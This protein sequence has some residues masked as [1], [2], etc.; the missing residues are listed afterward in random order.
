MLRDRN[1]F[2]SP[3]ADILFVSKDAL[4]PKEMDPAEK[5]CKMADVVLCLGTR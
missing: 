5:H 1:T 4:P 2:L 3:S